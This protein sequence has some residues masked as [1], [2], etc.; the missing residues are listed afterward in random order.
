MEVELIVLSRLWGVGLWFLWFREKSLRVREA[1]PRLLL[2]L[3]T[4]NDVLQKILS[5]KT[6]AS[7]PLNSSIVLNESFDFI[8]SGFIYIIKYTTIIFIEL[9]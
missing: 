5:S 9:E 4:R 8:L 7:I 1:I 2:S 6:R 3:L